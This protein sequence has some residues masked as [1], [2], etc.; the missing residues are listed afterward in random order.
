VNIDPGGLRIFSFLEDSL[1]RKPQPHLMDRAIAEMHGKAA[2]RESTLTSIVEIATWPEG[3][4]RFTDYSDSDGLS[5]EPVPLTVAVTVRGDRTL[6]VDWEGTSKQV[7]AA[8]NST[9]S[10][11]KSKPFLSVRC[12]LRGD[13]PN[14]AGVFRCIKVIAPEGSVLNPIP[15][16]PVAARADRL[17]RD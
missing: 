6:N 3:T 1:S 15:P 10:F 9:L 11:T 7:R 16:P 8:I 12:A 17:S 13:I 14:N 4:Y 2:A 5:D